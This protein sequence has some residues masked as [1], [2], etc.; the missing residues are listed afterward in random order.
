MEKYEPLF[1]PKLLV[2]PS[3]NEVRIAEVLSILSDNGYS[4][5]QI[6]NIC[7][8]YAETLYGVEATKTNI[9]SL[10]GVPFD[11]LDESSIAK[12]TEMLY[13]LADEGKSACLIGKNLSAKEQS[14]RC[15][16]F[17][18]AVKSE[19]E[20][21]LA[22]GNK[23]N[24]FETIAFGP[25]ESAEQQYMCDDLFITASMSLMRQPYEANFP[26]RGSSKLVFDERIIDRDML[27]S[28]LDGFRKNL[29]SA[30]AIIKDGRAID[31]KFTIYNKGHET[32]Y[33]KVM[34]SEILA[35]ASEN[36]MTAKDAAKLYNV[37]MNVCTI[38]E[39]DETK[40]SKIYEQ[41]KDLEQHCD[42]GISKGGKGIN[43][44]VVDSFKY[45]YINP[46]SKEHDATYKM[47]EYETKNGARH[48]ILEIHDKPSYRF[49][50]KT[51]NTENGPERRFLVQVENYDNWAGYL[52]SDPQCDIGE[53]VD[54]E[55][56]DKRLELIK[57]D[58]GDKHPNLV[59]KL[60]TLAE[61]SKTLPIYVDL[62]G[63]GGNAT[64]EFEGQTYSNFVRNP[65]KVAEPLPTLNMNLL[66]G[67]P[68]AGAEA[69]IQ[70]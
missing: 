48:T 60:E 51:V 58:L 54:S 14:E 49:T 40:Y 1:R 35:D 28:S 62:D 65:I 41:L 25:Y 34:L 63:R 46:A 38:N 23:V 19:P 59:A 8:K 69:G 56:T 52:L 2:K 64:I 16:A 55:F 13:D 31:M 10:V 29:M 9:K 22:V 11:K 68:T 18:S 66:N 21:E 20:G 42:A 30:E 36:A 47:A 17:L 24:G 7:N 32:G 57:K 53:L 70:M 3:C 61:D 15:S 4:S 37:V 5:H 27:P 6:R 45:D 43:A 67:I 44:V 26:N 39:F 50:T 33:D 12:N